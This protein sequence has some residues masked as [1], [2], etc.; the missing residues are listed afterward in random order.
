MCV[1]HAELYFNDG[2]NLIVG[3]NGQGKSTIL[4]AVALCLLEDKRSDRY[5]EFIMLGKDTCQ[6]ELD[7]DV[8]GSPI[9]IK[10]SLSTKTTTLARTAS[11]NGKV[12]TNS[13]VTDLLDSFDLGYYADIIMSM[14]NE[15]DITKL[16]PSEREAYLQK[17]FQFDFTEKVDK[18]KEDLTSIKGSI[19]YQNAQIEFNTKSI[20]KRRGEI[21]E[22]KSLSFQEGDIQSLNSRVKELNDE[23]SKTAELLK[24]KDEVLSKKSELQTTIYNVKQNITGYEHDIELIESNKGVIDTLNQKILDYDAQNVGLEKEKAGYQKD[25]DNLKQR[26]DAQ[27]VERQ[28][29]AESIVERHNTFIQRTTELGDINIQLANKVAELNHAQ[30]HLDMI[31]LG[32]C[33]ECGHAFDRTDQTKYNEALDLATKAK[34]EVENLKSAKQIEV[35]NADADVKALREKLRNKEI[36]MSNT[37]KDISTLEYKIKNLDGQI[38]INVASKARIEEQIKQYSSKMNE[39]DSIKAKIQEE[40]ES[41][42]NLNKELD[43]YTN[44]LTE[45]DGVT[46]AYTEKQSSLMQLQQKIS[47]YNNEIVQNNLIL[48]NNENIKKSIEEMTKKIEE[49]K[50]SVEGYRRQ[51]ATYDEAITLLDKTFPAWLILKTC[52]MLEHEMNSF[53]Q[54]IFPN[55]AVKLFQNK[56]GV[57]FFYTTDI[58]NG[59]VLTKDNLLNAKMASGFEKAILSIAFKVAL[60][61]AYNL[62]F[63]FMDEIDQAGTEENS[64]SLFKAILSNDLFDQLFVISHKPT[65]RDVIHS[66]APS[67]KTFYVNKGKFWSDDPN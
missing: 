5:Q 48:Q 46:T 21:K 38:Q 17:L 53:I 18:L 43:D 36:E 55:M 56:R 66:F 54:V 58:N 61:R 14:Q 52:Q 31:K 39:V 44:Q 49:S 67:L 30:K 57:E 34:E 28:D 65:V 4:Q 20:E 60:C 47:E 32:T 25:I 22:L 35:N 64:E 15:G 41:L 27:N 10:I 50:S 40:N 33:P 2:V 13:E 51:K 23:L 19:D 8:K 29:V 24:R 11:Y 3:N 16:K 26:L 42:V 9:S 6:V 1:E 12:Y 62:R 59:R 63:A 37:S 7:A 45:L